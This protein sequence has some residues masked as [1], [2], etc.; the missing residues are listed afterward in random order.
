MLKHEQLQQKK[1]CEEGGGDWKTISISRKGICLCPLHFKRLFHQVISVRSS[2]LLPKHGS[3][4]LTASGSPQHS[5]H[6]ARLAHLPS[7][8]QNKLLGSVPERVL[9]PQLLLNN[10]LSSEQ[11]WVGT[12]KSRQPGRV[13]ARSM[14]STRWEQLWE[15]GPEIRGRLL[16]GGSWHIPVP[17]GWNR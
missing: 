6:P 1:T 3:V 10:S 11:S 14:G 16:E 2:A 4:Q 8:W 12:P 7:C 5:R 9:Q 13:K 15:R 17:V